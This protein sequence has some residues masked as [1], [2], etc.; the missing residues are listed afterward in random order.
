MSRLIVVAVVVACL[1]GCSSNTGRSAGRIIG[2]PLAGPGGYTSMASV[3][4]REKAS[5]TFGDVVLGIHDPGLSWTL[6]RVSLQSQ[7]VGMVVVGV[8]AVLGRRTTTQFG[9]PPP[10]LRTLP[11]HVRGGASIA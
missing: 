6:E 4:I 10:G 1:G 2:G 3:P 7:P 5:L 9:Y 8:G 11:V